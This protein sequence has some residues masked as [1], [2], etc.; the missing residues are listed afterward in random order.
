MGQ[1]N[2]GLA[3]IRSAASSRIIESADMAFDRF[4]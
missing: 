1:R 4:G 3:T 2:P